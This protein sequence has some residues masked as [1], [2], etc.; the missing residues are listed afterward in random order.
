VSAISTHPP[1]ESWRRLFYA[2]VALG[3]FASVLLLILVRNVAWWPALA[4]GLAP[5]IGVLYGI[6]PGLGRGQL[7]PRAVPLYN[8]LHHSWGPVALGVLAV[9]A[10][11]SS[12]FFLG[13]LAWAAHLAIDRAIGLRLRSPE[14]FQRPPNP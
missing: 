12:G 7:H 11:L 13:A 9:A 2:A 3:L 4:F 5:D 1:A 10:G 14:G 6:A 8:L